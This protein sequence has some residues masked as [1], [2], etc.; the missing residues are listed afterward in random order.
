LLSPH[1]LLRWA[2]VAGADGYS[3]FIRGPDFYWGS[4]V[5]SATEVAYPEGAPELEAGVDYKLIVQTGS[6]S[7]ADEPGLGLGFAILGSK[8]R[9]AVQEQQRKIQSLGLPD[10]PT[11][12]LVAHLYS[13][14]E[15][16]AE[17]IQRL[18]ALSQTFKAD[19]VAQFLGSLYIDIGLTR[20]AEAYYLNSLE[21]SKSE[22]DEEGEMRVHLALASIYREALG[23]QKLAIEHLEIALALAQKMGDD[24]TARQ[25]R[26]QLAELKKIGM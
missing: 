19:A 5:R 9:K 11:Q 16:K 13:T 3:V 15:L 20:Q 2:A 10:E 17:A 6:R 8:E 24:Q 25:V 18:E 21:L 22:K 26:E 1:P 12:Y 4:Q 7:S 14:H 23:N